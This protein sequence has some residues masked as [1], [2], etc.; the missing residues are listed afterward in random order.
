MQLPTR[1]QRLL[2]QVGPGEAVSVGPVELQQHGGAEVWHVGHVGAVEA[3]AFDVRRRMGVR[4]SE[5]AA[6]ELVHVELLKRLQDRF[7]V[8]RQAEVDWSVCD[9]PRALS[10]H[11]WKG[12]THKNK[13]KS[14]FYYRRCKRYIKLIQL[15]VHYTVEPGYNKH[16][17]NENSVKRA[18]ALG[19]LK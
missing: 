18:F 11:L 15:H 1:Q 17:Y 3:Q 19:P 9:R 7:E 8:G 12:T 4:P 13:L 16:G 2:D 10:E 5:L 6:A 14:G